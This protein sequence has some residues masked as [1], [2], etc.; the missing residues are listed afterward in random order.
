MKYVYLTFLI[1]VFVLLKDNFTNQSRETITP[2]P[3]PSKKVN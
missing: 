3:G 1:I 2:L